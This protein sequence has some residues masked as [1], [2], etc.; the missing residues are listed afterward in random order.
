MDSVFSYPLYRDLAEQQ[1][2][3]SGLAGHHGFGANV[4]YRKQAA[5]VRGLLVSG[6]Y[7]STLGLN[8]AAGRLLG[9]D[10]DRTPGAHRV[11]VLAHSYWKQQF[12]QD[13]AI[14][15]QV[16]L[17]NGVPMTVIGVAPEDFTGTSFGDAAR[18]FV[19]LT[20]WEAL[21]PDWRGT[22]NRKSYWIYLF[23]RLRPG[24]GAVY[25]NIIRTVDFSLQPPMAAQ[26]QERFLNQQLRLE[27][28]A[29]GQSQLLEEGKT[30]ALLLSAITGFV[31]LIACANIANLMLSRSTNRTREF[32]IRLALGA[33]PAQI[34][35]QLLAESIVL[36]IL[37]GF[38]GLWFAQATGKVIV[39]FL[40]QSISGNLTLEL[41]L[42]TLL[43]ALAVSIVAGFLMGLFPAY[44]MSRLDLAGAMRDQA[45]HLSGARPANLFRRALV[46]GQ[47]TLSLVLLV[48]AGTF[49]KS[50][51][52]VLRVDLGLRTENVITYRISPDRNQ[53]QP[54]VTR[55]LFEN[56][57]ARLAALPGVQGVALSLVPLITGSRWGSGVS[58]EGF[59]PGV[60]GN[61][62]SNFNRVNAGF[63]RVLAIPLLRGREFSASDSL[64]SAKVA[65]VN[66][67]FE[68]KFGQ[69]RSLLGRR[70]GIE[71][72]N[73]I[74]I[75]GIVQDVKYS[76]VKDAVGPVF[77][78]PSRQDLQL[79]SMSFY[80]ATAVPYTRLT[81][82]FRR[83]MAEVDPNL[84][85]E[86]MESFAAQVQEDI[87]LDRMVSTLA[88][89]FALL[90]TLL[91]VF[92]LYGVLAYTVSRRTREFGIRMAI[93]AD[94]P[95]IR[96]LV[97]RE[98]TAMLLV[99][100]LL[101]MPLGWALMQFAQDL[102]YEIKGAETA[103]IFLALAL[104][105]T[106]S[107]LAGWLP[108]R[109][110]MRVAPLEALR[111][112]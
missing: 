106:V 87:G 23:G 43:F 26:Q 96:D 55:A 8:A 68:R 1:K 90:A 74:Q 36:A 49:L 14:L 21:I 86:D 104:L 31:L 98:V 88:I 77:F 38:A 4:A 59:V 10:D 76:T 39:S 60:D 7:F 102:L 2:A 24:L 18:L 95:Q 82:T 28:G 85:V 84:P 17:I 71:G 34:M 83:V 19:P 110:A 53:Y 73:D 97:M 54:E 13:P 41:Q 29:K 42:E 107:L 48:S 72:R 63:F 91:A 6:S 89:A 27:P 58:V 40:L 47:I 69:G 32:S 3:L 93:G 75:V 56:A 92:G 11:A 37:A 16:L 52:N 101:G 45:A 66:E 78:L 50:L 108:A 81:A 61:D 57:E 80:I 99:G 22:N 100:V 15:G 25:S 33:S 79:G 112:E 62:H 30:P 5:S 94:G 12:N 9:P 35:R 65:V 44:H 46:I 64:G 70:M 109:R 111:Y 105:T 20:M 103:V 67:A 51:V